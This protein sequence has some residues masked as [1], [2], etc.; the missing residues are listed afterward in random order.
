[1]PDN[2]ETDAVAERYARRKTSKNVQQHSANYVYNH[3]I[4]SE[5]ELVYLELLH[6][7][8]SDI[9]T[10]R[11]LEIG[12]GHGTNL[13]F[14][15]K[16]GIPWENIAANELL[17]ERLAVLKSD[18]P[19]VQIY[20]GDAAT[21][22]MK[23]SEKGFDVVFQSTV[24]TSILDRKIRQQLARVMWDLVLPGGMVLWY[25]FVYDNPANPDVKKVTRTEVKQLFPNADNIFFKSVTLAPPIGRRIGRWYP[26]F[27]LFPFL[28]THVVAAIHKK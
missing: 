5:R 4:Q 26:L 17:P 7:H 27:N 6:R 10:L 25:D 16:A 8:F 15:K 14:M 9:E 1:M 23:E 11:I 12:A 20:E 28:R 2:K 3:F 21:I 22:K 13:H 19:L 24:F 18:F